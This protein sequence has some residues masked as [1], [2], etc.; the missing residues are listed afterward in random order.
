MKVVQ[1]EHVGLDHGPQDVDLGNG[2]SARYR[3]PA[4]AVERTRRLLDADWVIAASLVRAVA[5]VLLNDHTGRPMAVEAYFGN[6][7]DPEGGQCF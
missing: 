7:V 4:A 3:T 6:Y 1:H 2:A 5:K